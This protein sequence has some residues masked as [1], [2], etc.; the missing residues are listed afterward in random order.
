MSGA[1]AVSVVVPVRDDPRV[2][3]LLA[4][5]AAQR[6]GPDFEVLVALDGAT[7]IPRVPAGLPARLLPG[8]AAGPY[9][10]RNRGVREATGEIVAFTDSD[11]L[12][13]P[14]WLAGL[15]AAVGAGRAAAIQ[16]AS[17]AA[18]SSRLSVF[19]QR[20]YDRYVASH[21][22]AGFRRFCNTRNFAI[23]RQL[24]IEMPLPEKFPRGGDGAYGLALERAGVPIFYAEDWVVLHRHARSRLA[25]ARI[26][27]EQGRHGAIWE[28]EG[29]ALFGEGDS[30]RGPGAW[31][32]RRVRAGSVAGAA[33]GAGLGVAAAALGVA[34]AVIPG[35]I[36]YRAFSR[37][38][39]AAHLAGRISASPRG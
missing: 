14:D 22:A 3:D 35:E 33:A 10:A 19:I 11:C 25:V 16:G 15:G 17:A 6:G 5:L 4:S 28:Q 9:A 21:A 37:F 24:A 31:L 23:R 2:D 13:P 7:R 1:V 38:H 12:C 26:A 34:S 36:G 32:V 39:R 27:Y 20:E 30:R 18:D 29:A 8:D